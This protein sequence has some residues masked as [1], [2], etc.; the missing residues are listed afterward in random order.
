MNLAIDPM[1]FFHQH[2]LQFVSFLL[3]PCDFRFNFHVLTNFILV[4]L[5]VKKINMETSFDF[6]FWNVI[7]SIQGSFTDF[8]YV[9]NLDMFKHKSKTGSSNL[10]GL[11]IIPNMQ[12]VQR[13]QKQ[14]R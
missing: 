14:L 10:F 4:L 13:I 11:N 3:E 2:V 1:C 8:D 6:A 9:R 12:Q 5:K 7:L